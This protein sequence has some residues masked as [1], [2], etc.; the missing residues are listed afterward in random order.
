MIKEAERIVKEAKERGLVL[1][2]MGAIA[3]HIHCPKYADL[4]R[5]LERL[6]EKMFPDIDFMSIKESRKKLPEFF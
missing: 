6:R 1:R 2:I 3:I 4:H 5:R